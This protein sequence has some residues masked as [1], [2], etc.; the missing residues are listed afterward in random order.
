MTWQLVNII[1]GAMGL[2]FNYTYHPWHGVL[3]F[4]VRCLH[5]F[6]LVSFPPRSSLSDSASG[7]RRGGITALGSITS[8]LVRGRDLWCFR[9]AHTLPLAP[10]DGCPVSWGCTPHRSLSESTESRSTSNA[11]VS[12]EQFFNNSGWT[13][14]PYVF[15][16]G[17]SYCTIASGHDASAQ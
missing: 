13:S 9:V 3:F 7:L 14:K 2:A 10:G 15:V 11:S 17:W 16:L 1:H 5:L 8:F 12:P 4:L 6:A